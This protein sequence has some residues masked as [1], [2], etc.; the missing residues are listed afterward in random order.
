MRVTGSGE[1]GSRFGH[2]LV[3]LLQQLLTGFGYRRRHEGLSSWGHVERIVLDGLD[4]PCGNVG[5]V[6]GEPDHA[7]GFLMWLP[8]KLSF[9]NTLQRLA[10]TG[11]FLIELG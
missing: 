1:S 11:H 8:G 3:E 2:V 9:G 6:S 10:G 4:S 5:K 7:A